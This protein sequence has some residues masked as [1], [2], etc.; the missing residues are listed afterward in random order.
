MLDWTRKNVHDWLMENNLIQM[1]QLLVDCNGSSLVY[2]SDFIKNGETKQVL[3]LLQ[4]ESLRRTNEGLSLVELSYFQSLLD[5][6]RSVMRSK[7]SRRSLRNTNRRK[8][9]I[10]SC[11]QII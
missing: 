8:K 1:S 3:N 5:Q 7:V 11:C 4:E 6:Q 2:L 9:L 10:S